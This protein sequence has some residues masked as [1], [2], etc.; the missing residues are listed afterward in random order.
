MRDGMP[1]AHLAI[2]TIASLFYINLI[3]AS[4][5]A[6][7]AAFQLTRTFIYSLD[8]KHVVFGTVVEG[9]WLTFCS[10]CNYRPI[11]CV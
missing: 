7:M 6:S 10:S 1:L 9:E 3:H 4:G 5:I 11:Y 2:N 8:G